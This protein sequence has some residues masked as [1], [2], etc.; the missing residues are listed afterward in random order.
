MG[1]IV[2]FDPAAFVLQFPAFAAVPPDTLTM[3]FGMAEGFLNNTPASIVQDLT[4]R[5]NLLYLITAHIAFLMGRAGSGDGSQAALVGQM[6]SA[7]EGTV[8]AAFAAVQAKNAAFWAQSQYGMLFWQMSL[9][10]RSFLYLPA[11]NVC[12]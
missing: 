10:Y 11:P 4:I 7:G 3:Y 8:N 5:T 1:G 9:P 12:C 2:T 6:T